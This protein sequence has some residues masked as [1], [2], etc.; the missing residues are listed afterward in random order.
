M[1]NKDK[2][3]KELEDKREALELK[4]D[5][6]ETER[7]TLKEDVADLKLKKKIEDE[8]IKHMVKMK[9]EALE[10]KFQKKEM[11]LE[12][13][14]NNEVAKVKDDYRDKMES[15]LE[16]RGTEIKG[17]YSEILERLPNVNVRLKKEL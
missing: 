7:D 15:Q 2:K 3:I 4:N 9:E 11:E 5:K 13:A 14:K 10:I 6:L 1:F 8:D 17:M 16:K 12:K